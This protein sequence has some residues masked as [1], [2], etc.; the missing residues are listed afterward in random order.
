MVKIKKKR[1]IPSTPRRRFILEEGIHEHSHRNWKLAVDRSK[2]IQMKVD[3]KKVTMV[4]K[5]ATFAIR[6]SSS[7]K[8][9]KIPPTRGRI[10]TRRRRLDSHMEKCFERLG[11]R[12]GLWENNPFM[13]LLVGMDDKGLEPL[14]PSV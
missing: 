2:S 1:E 11:A 7:K 5:R 8:R 6:A 3:K 14:A 10:M 12:E 4:K 9:I 13:T